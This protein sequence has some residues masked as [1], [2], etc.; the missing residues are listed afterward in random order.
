[1][2]QYRG[3]VCSAEISSLMAVA[4]TDGSVFQP[5][6]PEVLFKLPPQYVRLAS[7]L[8]ALAGAMANHQRLLL[9]IPTEETERQEVSVILNW[10]PM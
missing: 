10:H 1:M 4:L 5:S 3:W 2:E 7:N 9:S 8:G 6:R